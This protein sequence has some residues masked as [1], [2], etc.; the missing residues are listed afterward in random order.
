MRSKAQHFQILKKR[1]SL[2]KLIDTLES[3]DDVQNAVANFE[4]SEELIT[5]NI[6]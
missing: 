3:L 1:R 5:A 4:I 6:A 2:L